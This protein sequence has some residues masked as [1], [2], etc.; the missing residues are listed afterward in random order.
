MAKAEFYEI[1]IKDKR[2]NIIFD[3]EISLNDIM[4]KYLNEKNENENFCQG[5]NCAVILNNFLKSNDTDTVFDLAKFTDEKVIS[6]LISKPTSSEDT[7]KEYHNKIL[8]TT[9]YNNHEQKKVEEIISINVSFEMIKKLKLL[10]MDKFKMYK[11]ILDNSLLEKDDLSLFEKNII[12]RLKKDSIFFNIIEDFEYSKSK[13]L[14]WHSYSHGLD[15]KYLEMYLNT[16][17][18]L[19]EEFKITFHK[20]YDADF[21]DLLENGELNSFAFSFNIESKNNLLDQDLFSPLYYLENI[22]GENDTKVEIKAKKDE[23]LD[24]KKLLSFFELASDNGLLDACEL[25][26]KGGKNKKIDFKNKKLNIEYTESINILNIDDAKSFFERGLE[27]KK[28]ILKQ[29]LGI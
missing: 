26:P 9:Q 15:I 2:E 27:S 1:V 13:L 16:H 29:R 4:S 3:K 20:L 7:F 11:I 18:L 6:T 28:K 10:D 19:E 23:I 22:F 21:M 25:K 24:N 5:K 14:I 17:L 8:E 12:K